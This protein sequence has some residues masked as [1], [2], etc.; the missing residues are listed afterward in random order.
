M[1][2]THKSFTSLFLG[3]SC[4][5]LL[6]CCK[7]DDRDHGNGHGTQ[8]KTYPS[9]VLKEW[10]KMDLQLLRSNDA[11]LNNFVMMHHWAYSSIALYEA[12]V[13]GMP[14]YQ[15]LSGQLSDMPA[16]PRTRHDEIYHWPTCANAALASMTRN[17][18]SDSITQGGKDSINLLE[19]SL[20][21]LY[22]TESRA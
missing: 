9:D 1:K 6:V 11:K 22:Q 2:Y 18:Y 16:M 8:T 13:P 7:K 21:N 20:N 15:S 14:S 19:D 10:I 3:L 17:F 5:V 12:V 4:F